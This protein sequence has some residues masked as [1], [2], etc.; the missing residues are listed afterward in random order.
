[1]HVQ[2][3][4]TQMKSLRKQSHFSLH[5]RVHWVFVLIERERESGRVRVIIG[6]EHLSTNALM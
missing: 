4:W 6:S 5:T 1:M 3:M 2:Y